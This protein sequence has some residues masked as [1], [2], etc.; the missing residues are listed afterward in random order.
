MCNVA[1][2]LS[3]ENPDLPTNG[4][5]SGKSQSDKLSRFYKSRSRDT[6]L[7]ETAK[8]MLVH[9]YSPGKTALLLR[10]PYDLVK[11]LYDN[12]WNPRC[13]RV[14]HTSQYATKRMAR[15]YFDS[16]AMLA[17]IC[18]D[19][20]LPLFTVVT[21]LK[22]EGITEKEMASRMPDQHDPLFVAYRETVARKQKNPQRRSPRLHY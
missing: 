19:L 11:G 5:A 16:G 12:S 22:R 2:G 13:R 21:L 9:G 1:N 10:L 7:I 3:A 4:F 18:A 8:K 14:T 15:M 20:Q 6:S 17:K